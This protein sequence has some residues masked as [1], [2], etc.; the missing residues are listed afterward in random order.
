MKVEKR[1]EENEEM[2]KEEAMRNGTRRGVFE[3]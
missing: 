3:V 1:M 2:I